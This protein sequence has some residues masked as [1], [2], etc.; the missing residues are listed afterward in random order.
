MYEARDVE[1]V[2][3]VLS[4]VEI[5]GLSACSCSGS[6]EIF[7]IAFLMVL[8]FFHMKTKGTNPGGQQWSVPCEF[9]RLH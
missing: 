3:Q 9:E 8:H 2:L 5:P 7:T 4:Y 6:L 1:V